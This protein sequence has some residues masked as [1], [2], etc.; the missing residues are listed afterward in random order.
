M[1]SRH[2]NELCLRLERVVDIGCAEIRKSE[3]LL[4]YGQER[5][6]ASIWR[7]VQEKWIEIAD[8]VPLLVGNA[9]GVWVLVWGEG[10]TAPNEDE[11]W[12][13]SIENFAKLKPAKNKS[14]KRRATK[15]S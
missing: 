3:L 4:W 12:F 2:T 1:L 14:T 11:A 10:L 5:L 6:T 13:Q 7:D 15:E 8:N 9:D